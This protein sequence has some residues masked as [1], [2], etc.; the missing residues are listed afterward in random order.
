MIKRLTRLCGIIIV[1][2]LFGCAEYHK[3]TTSMLISNGVNITSYKDVSERLNNLEI[4]KWQVSI[5]N[6]NSYPVCIMIK[7]SLLDLDLHSYYGSVI[8]LPA[9][10]HILR[11]ATIKQHMQELDGVYFTLPPSGYIRE[12]SVKDDTPTK[13]DCILRRI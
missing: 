7:W 12:L 8:W 3:P 4:Q 2:L 6:H 5:F 1:G 13:H 11:F 9:N 10:Q